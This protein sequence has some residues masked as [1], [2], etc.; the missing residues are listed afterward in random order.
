M[1]ADPVPAPAPTAAG[2][3]PRLT[4]WR[5]WLARLLLAVLAPALV[6]GG[7]ELAL[8]L[9]GYG[10]PT[11][12]FLP[13]DD[14]RSYV[15]NEQF[16]LSFLPRALAPEP[17]PAAFPAAKPP[18]TVRV[19]VFGESAALGV[20]EPAMNFGRILE[21]LLRRRYPG[22]CFEVVNAAVKGVNS[23]VLLPVARDCAGHEPDLFVVYMGNNEVV[24]LYGPGTMPGDAKVPGLASLRAG[25]W[26]KTTRVGQLLAALLHRKAVDEEMLRQSTKFL[27]HRVGLDDPRR[28]TVYDYYRANLRDIAEAGR[29]AG[30]RVLLCTVGVNLRDCPPLASLHRPDLSA[31]DQGRWAAYYTRAT[32]ADGVGD[33][34]AAADAYRAALALDDRHAELH[35]RLARALEALGDFAEA[36]RH[37]SL[38]RDLDALQ[39]RADSRLNEIVREEASAGDGLYLVDAEAAFARNPRAVHGVPGAEAFYEH[40]HLRFDGSYVLARAVLDGAA[41]ALADAGIAPAADAEPPSRDECARLLVYTTWNEFR[42]MQWIERVYSQ[43]PLNYQL[44]H[45]QRLARVREELAALARQGKGDGV[46]RA[47]DAYR[48]ALAEAPDDWQLRLNFGR[49]LLDTG[50]PAAAVE[51]FRAA[52]ELLPWSNQLRLSLADGLIKAGK[53]SEAIVVLDEVLRRRPDDEAA[54]RMLEDARKA[55]R[56]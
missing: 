21:I 32:A 51:Q 23:H 44:G 52:H 55:E 33:A 50:D 11:A 53:A 20:P 31:A 26:L 45:E 56:P 46:A 16:A 35:F 34:R 22:V 7:T 29:A 49:L 14:G 37:Y 28:Q 6:L 25:H 30:A 42:C 47:R 8:R 9:C 1:A 36:A 43:P 17:Y 5:K 54:A 39:F 15:T 24:G 48:A 38:A 41:Q 2:P 18:G 40:V 10:R 19:F 13:S 3:R 27:E 4:G 12:F